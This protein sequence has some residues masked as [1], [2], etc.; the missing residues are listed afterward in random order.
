MCQARGWVWWIKCQTDLLSVQFGVKK[1]LTSVGPQC[2]LL[3]ALLVGVVR[4]KGYA[5]DSAAVVIGT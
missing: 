4:L 2:P 5:W 3:P 1:S